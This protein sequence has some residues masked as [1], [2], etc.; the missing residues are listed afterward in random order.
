MTFSVLDQD[1]EVGNVRE[2]L[3]KMQAMQ[4]SI[5]RLDGG[6]ISIAG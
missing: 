5:I 1:Y 4:K 2:S 6:F 3:F